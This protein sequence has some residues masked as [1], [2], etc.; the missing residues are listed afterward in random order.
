MLQ[1]QLTHFHK[2]KKEK[3]KLM[4]LI[5][6]PSS[7]IIIF[8]GNALVMMLCFVRHILGLGL[9]NVW[10]FYENLQIVQ[11]E[12]KLSDNSSDVVGLSLKILELPGE[13]KNLTPWTG[14]WQV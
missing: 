1:P 12:R 9:G 11:S 4:I 3:S 5:Y 14:S 2:I 6:S 10:N 13:D 8:K 7:T